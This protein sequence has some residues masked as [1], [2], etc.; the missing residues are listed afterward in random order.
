MEMIQ[1]TYGRI[2]NS[3]VASQPCPS[4]HIT[5]DKSKIKEFPKFAYRLLFARR[6]TLLQKC[7]RYLFIHVSN[8]T[9][10]VDEDGFSK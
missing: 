4:G 9:Q 6:Y 1:L 3:A 10:K 8:G 5:A 7:A 2:R